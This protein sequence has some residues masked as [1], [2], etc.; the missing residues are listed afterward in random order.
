MAHKRP[1]KKAKEVRKKRVKAR[2]GRV[3]CYV[4]RKPW[5]D[6]GIG[7]VVAVAEWVSA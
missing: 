2:Q 6:G 5:N 1:G 7:R 3:R 4:Y